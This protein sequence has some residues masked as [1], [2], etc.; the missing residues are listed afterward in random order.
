MAAICD[1]WYVHHVVSGDVGADPPAD[2]QKPID[3]AGEA[4]CFHGHCHG[5]L[6]PFCSE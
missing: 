6:E 1:R 5:D 4:V 2:Q 3:A